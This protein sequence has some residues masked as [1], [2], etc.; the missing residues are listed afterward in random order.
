MKRK[1]P[2]KANPS[3]EKPRII[4]SRRLAKARGGVDL[5]I[6]TVARQHQRLIAGLASHARFSADDTRRWGGCSWPT[7]QSFV[8]L[9]LHHG[10]VA[11]A[12]QE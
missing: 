12:A 5:G 4:E 8:E 11:R 1:Q 6:F 7:A 10:I 3:S 9:M 2:A